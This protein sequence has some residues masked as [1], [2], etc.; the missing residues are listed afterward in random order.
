MWYCLIYVGPAW[1]GGKVMLRKML[2][3]WV[4]LSMAACSAKSDKTSQADSSKKA[5]VKTQNQNNT[6]KTKKGASAKKAEA[7]KP[8]KQQKTAATPVASL[9]VEAVLVEVNGTV[10][11]NRAESDGYVPAKTNDEL[12]VG[13]MVRVSGTQGFARLRMWDDTVIIL[14]PGSEVSINPG[15][16]V[17][18]ASPSITVLAGLSSLMVEPRAEGQDVFTVY[19]PTAELAV[20][21]TEFDVGIALTGEVAVGVSEGIVQV[22]VQGEAKARSVRL[23]HGKKVVIPPRAEDVKV[24]PYTPEKENWVGWLEK[25][26]EEA[27]K[28]ADTVVRVTDKRI[29]QLKKNLD[30][31][32]K[33][34]S[35]LEKKLSER[36]AKLEAAAK[37]GDPKAYAQQA[38]PAVELAVEGSAGVQEIRRLRSMM[39]ANAY[40]LARLQA[41]LANAKDIPPEQ[42]AKIEARIKPRIAKLPE[43]RVQLRQ[44]HRRLAQAMRSFRK[45]Y[46]LNTQQGRKVAPKLGIKLPPMYAKLPALKYRRPKKP[47]FLRGIRVLRPRLRYMGKRRPHVNRPRRR[48]R[49]WVRRPWRPADPARVGRLNR[50]RNRY[51]AMRRRRV[52]MPRWRRRSRRRPGMMP[53]GSVRPIPRPV[54]HPGR[55]GV[56]PPLTNPVNPNVVRPGRSQLPAMGVPGMLPRGRRPNIPGRGVMPR[57]PPNFGMGA[58]GPRRNPVMGRG[59]RRPLP[60]GVRRPHLPGRR[61]RVMGPRRPLPP[62]MAD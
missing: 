37:K 34:I 45:M 32:N 38:G 56:R 40:L 48:G 8:K 6:A 51:R 10:E 22:T 50:L 23:E 3:F 19:T 26:S 12:H 7:A 39:V 33:S 11:V 4:V 24:V 9:P 35:D 59:R 27:E 21:G 60:P 1:T 29:E 5:Q 46:Y 30:E 44:D 54:F 20:L 52:V 58:M 36:R 14:S 42:K 41:L 18:G 49:G 2:T 28:K 16:D 62:T 43:L 47:R 25:K 31:L 57:R 61:P 17:E 53:P 13:D 15:A 55:P